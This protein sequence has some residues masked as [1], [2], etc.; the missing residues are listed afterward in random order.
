MRFLELC[1]CVSLGCAHLLYRERHDCAFCAC[2]IL[3]GAHA[4][5]DSP[6]VSQPETL[7]ELGADLWFESSHE[8]VPLYAEPVNSNRRS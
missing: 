8:L 2:V 7:K 3:N 6:T 5:L 1:A 4:L